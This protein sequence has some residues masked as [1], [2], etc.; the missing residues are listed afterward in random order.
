MRSRR[1][2]AFET[3]MARRNGLPESDQATLDGVLREARRSPAPHVGDQRS[4]LPA[5]PSKSSTTDFYRQPIDPGGWLFPCED[6]EQVTRTKGPTMFPIIGSANTHF[7]K[8]H[9][10]STRCRSR[11]RSAG[12]RQAMRNSRNVTTGRL[13]RSANAK[14]QPSRATSVVSRAVDPEPHDGEIHSWRLRET[15]IMLVGDGGN[16]VVQIGDEGAFVVD[17]GGGRLA[18]KTVA[19]IQ[20]LSTSR[21]NDCEYELSS[22]HTAV[23]RSSDLGLRSQREGTFLALQFRMQ[24]PRRRS[25]P[26]RTS[27][28]G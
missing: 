2:L 17:T 27:C 13:M 20:R 28:P 15:F 1:D 18:D 7:S 12:R 24:A 10:R 5:E 23:T 21:F 8:E 25:C 11:R 22:G 16:V 4:R 3:R 6:S 14:L 19:A 26:M 9:G